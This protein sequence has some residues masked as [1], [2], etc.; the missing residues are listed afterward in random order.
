L[1][2]LVKPIINK[3]AYLF[4]ICIVFA[5]ILIAATRMVTPVLDKY[6]PDIEVWASQL[7]DGPVKIEKTG[8]S[9]YQYQPVVTLHNVTFLDKGS[10]APVLQI[11]RVS[12]L[13]SIFSSVW[14]WKP[15]LSGILISGTD[16]KIEEKKNGEYVVQGFP[17]LGGF[18]SQPYEQESK[19]T[20]TLA[21][22]SEQPHIILRDI[23]IRYTG[24]KGEKRF[25][26][27]DRFN[28]LNETSRH[29]ITGKAILHQDLPTEAVVALEW[30][31]QPT[32]LAQLKSKIYI[33]VSGLSF[34]QWFKDYEYLGWR[35]KEGIGSAKVWATWDKGTF[36]RIQSEFQLYNLEL[37]SKTSKSMHPLRRLSGMLGWQRQGENQII[38]GDDILIDLSNHLWPVTSF[39]ITLAPDQEKSLMPTA[40]QFGYIDLADVQDWLF[41]SANALPEDTLKTLADLHLTGGL[42]NIKMKFSQPW[43]DI[44]KTS[45]TTDFRHISIAPK[46]EL[47]TVKNLSGS[48]SWDGR[49]GQLNIHSQ[50]TIFEDERI[51]AAPIIADQLLGAVK[52]LK[53]EN[54]IWLINAESLQILNNDLAANLNGSLT[55]APDKSPL[56]DITGNFTMEKVNRVTHYLPLKLFEKGLSDWLKQAFLSGEIKSGK[57]LLKG[58]LNDFPFEQGKGEFSVKANISHI[59]FRF[60]PDW[61]PLM[62]TN[63]NLFFL[64][65]RLEINIDQAKLFDIF[66]N[67]V[68][69]LMPSLFGKTPIVLSVEAGNIQTDFSKAMHF[70]HASPLENTIGKMFKN[71]KLNGPIAMQLGLTVPLA[72]PDQTQVHGEIKIRN[73]KMAMPAWNLDLEKLL[74]IVRFTENTVTGE[75]LQAN[76]FGESIYFNLKT[77]QKPDAKS[78][79]QAELKSKVNL[80]DLQKWLN[81][82]LDKVAK[83]STDITGKLDLSME[84]PIF[85]QLQSN[86]TGVAIDLPDQYV[87]K[88]EEE[89]AFSLE[90]TVQENHPVKLKIRYADLLGAALV[91]D[92]QINNFKLKAADLRLGAGDPEWPVENG[93]Y[94]TGSLDTISWDEAKKYMSDKN[95]ESF[96]GLSFRGL[97]ITFKSLDMLGLQLEN[98]TLKV[99]AKGNRW[100]VDIA[101]STVQGEIDLPKQF[102]SKESIRADF[103]KVI[104]KQAKKQKQ[105]TVEIDFKTLPALSININQLVY[106]D[107]QIGH[108]NLETVPKNAGQVIKS[109]RVRTPNLSMQSSG[110]WSKDKTQ[111]KGRA[112]SDSV[113]DYLNEMGLDAHNFVSNKGKLDFNLS[114]KDAL[115]SPS[116]ATMSGSGSIVLGAGRIV[117]VGEDTDAKLGIGRMLSLFSLQTIPRRLSLDFSDLFQ[118]GYSF[119]SI[120]G[121]FI[122]DDGDAYTTNT[123]F[124]GPVATVVIDGR[125]GLDDK[126]FDLTLNIT[127]IGITSTLPVAAAYLTGPVGGFAALAVNTVIGSQI[128]KAA[129]HHYEVKGPWS[130]PSFVQ[131]D[132]HGKNEKP[133]H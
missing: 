102:S 111:L 37:Y 20:D 123:R 115:Y 129:T 50:K 125:I 48:F 128:S 68:K 24:L 1:K 75:E 108:I 30:E 64:G 113:S 22:L 41:S 94:I 53:N 33:Y 57:L 10:K 89:R 101:S 12:V 81:M 39:H 79:I 104:F 72:R 65:S 14:Q 59:D 66:V 19:F 46:K 42:Q 11:K 28:L 127:P 106:N 82:P 9:W 112:E 55:L 6:R 133:S 31:G 43:T 67:Q 69:G 121:D 29:F 54:Q 84:A 3:T 110:N 103:Q 63:G 73:A 96:A 74:G 38:A 119:D 61:P 23:D 47:P 8:F 27:L 117:D 4:S 5:A 45:V 60:A 40:A 34:S 118:K 58:A 130:N 105:G 83:G 2:R 86:L 116:I 91:L 78:I 21:W 71:L 15:V 107:M 131:I 32:S 17:A 62:Q 26:S 122:L 18:E 80:S 98:P 114:W 92:K 49:Q 132:D 99:A 87:K 52:W 126:D 85:I 109:L 77:I 35:L 51:F 16:V 97:N 90:M 100:L 25:V 76:L 70:V 124:V 93:L 36:Q 13:F 120:R 44:Q 7:L 88:L 95:G 56:V